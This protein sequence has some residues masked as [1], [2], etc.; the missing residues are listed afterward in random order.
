[1]IQLEQQNHGDSLHLRLRGRWELEQ[2]AQIRTLL[3]AIPRDPA[4]FILDAREAE[5]LDVSTAW[6]VYN[7]LQDL[8]Q[9]GKQVSIEG[10]PG[11][12]L[13]YFATEAAPPQATGRRRDWRQ[14]VI[15]LGEKSVNTFRLLF[16]AIAFFGQGL[17]SLAGILIAPRNLRF[18]AMLHHIFAT[19]ISAIPIVAMVACLISIV[20]TYQGGGQLRELGATIYTV[21]MV[22]IS[23]LRELGVLLTAIVVAGRSGSAFAAEIGLMKTNQEVDALKVMGSNPFIIL[24]LP[25]LLA[26]LIALPLLTLIADI[27]AL[28]AAA[29]IAPFL[30]DISFSQ[31]FMRVQ[32]GVGLSTFLAGLIKAPFFALVIAWIGCWQGMQVTGSSESLGEHTTSAVVQSTLLVLLLD[33]LFSILFY[34]LGF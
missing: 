28:L 25:R 22:A 11:E 33:A 2:L 31:F 1:M 12:Y 32:Y 15:R 29:A 13:T 3:A 18:G 23:V 24:V 9:Q 19:G 5:R 26:L 7:H 30:L 27:L 14:P 4:T 21:D 20:I 16:S 6:L 17:S 8:Q 34:Q 10:F